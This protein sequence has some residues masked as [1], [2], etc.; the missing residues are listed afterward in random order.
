MNMLTTPNQNQTVS[1]LSY[2]NR[3]KIIREGVHL[4][5]SE[6][7]HVEAFIHQ[8]NLRNNTEITKTSWNLKTKNRMR[9][10]NI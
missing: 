4:R 10:K 6:L 2:E 3:E 7:I 8:T 5:D 1:S 9:F